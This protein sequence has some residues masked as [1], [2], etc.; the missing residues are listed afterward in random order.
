MIQV[1]NE[2]ITVM[3]RPE[4]RVFQLSI[5]IQ[6]YLNCD[7]DVLQKACELLSDNVDKELIFNDCYHHCKKEG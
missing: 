5:L 3:G 7:I 2:T 6:H 4:V 1:N